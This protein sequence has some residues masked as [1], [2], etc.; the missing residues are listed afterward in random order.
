MYNIWYIGGSV[1]FDQDRTFANAFEVSYEHAELTLQL[2]HTAVMS[3][4]LNSER[5]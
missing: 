5:F 2:R 1:G 3:S 4:G